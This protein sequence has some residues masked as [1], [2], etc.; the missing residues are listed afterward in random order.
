MTQPQNKQPEPWKTTGSFPPAFKARRPATYGTDMAV[1]EAIFEQIG[2]VKRAMPVLGLEKSAVYLLKASAGQAS[3]LQVRQLTAAGSTAAAEDL[4]HLAGGIFVPLPKGEGRL[5]GLTVEMV[6]ESGE[7][8]ATLMEALLD[9]K[10]TASEAPGAM[11][12]LDELSTVI[13]AIRAELQVI[14][15]GGQGGD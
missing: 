7:A 3:Y 4:A 9:R 14:A 15:D 2:G 6:R 10:V 8:T 13:A 1:I 11:Q 5:A 12:A